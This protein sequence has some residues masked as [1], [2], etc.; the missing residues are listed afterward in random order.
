VRSSSTVATFDATYRQ[1]GTAI[2]V[3]NR[4]AMRRRDVIGAGLGALGSL[5][6]GP[7]GAAQRARRSGKGMRIETA[8]GPVPAEALGRVLMHEHVLVDFIGADRVSPERYD[9]EETFRVALPHLRRVRELGCRTL[10]E[11][12]P[13]YLGRDPKL[14]RRLSEASGLHLVTNTGWYGAAGGKFLPE[15]AK[16]EA[17]EQIAARWI[18]EA[19]DGIAGTGIRPGFIKIGVD[20]APL[21]EVNRKIVRA[22][23][24]THLATG[25]TIAQHSG[26]GAAALEA[27]DLLAAEG[28]AGGAFLWVHAQSEMDG[29]LHVE[30]ARRG[31]WVEFDGIAPG[32]VERHVELVRAMKGAGQLSRVLVSH[33]AGWYNVGE[34]NGGT[35][36]GYETLFTEF[37]PALRKAGFSAADEET[38]LVGNPRAALSPTARRTRR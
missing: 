19:H 32:T 9:P 14:L 1:A 24:R 16:T 30:A 7:S 22:A 25:L 36:R 18:R 11:C 27:L 35:Y 26:S 10:V 28:V 4:T 38:L 34:P 5:V 17:V 31:A 33:D 12:T 23:A 21:P 13:A 20:G 8:R 29:K 6:T 2:S 37:L 15:L 3:S